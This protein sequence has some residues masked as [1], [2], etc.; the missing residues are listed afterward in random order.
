MFFI[1]T[2]GKAWLTTSEF[3]LASHPKKIY[4][5]IPITEDNPTST[6]HAAKYLALGLYLDIIKPDAKIP[7]AEK[8]KATVPVIRL[9]TEADCLYCVSIYFGVKIQ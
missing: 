9:E 8:V 4:Q 2:H 5:I 1:Y 7:I 6:F 3:S